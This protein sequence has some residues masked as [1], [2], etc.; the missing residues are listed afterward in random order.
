[1]AADQ[2]RFLKFP[3]LNGSCG[4]ETLETKNPEELFDAAGEAARGLSFSHAED[5]ARLKREQ[6]FRPTPQL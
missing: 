2:A 6:R 4:L 5:S 1:M 3:V